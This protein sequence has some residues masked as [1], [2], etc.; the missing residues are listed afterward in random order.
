MEKSRSTALDKNAEAVRRFN[1]YYTQRIGVL[2]EG[3]LQS[4]FS[5]TQ[6]RVLYELAYA[7]LPVI[8]SDLAKALG[9]DTGYLSRI[10][11]GFEKERL[12]T[13]RVARNDARQNLVEITHRG[14]REFAPLDEASHAQ[15]AGMLRQIPAEDHPRLLAAMRTIEDVLSGLEERGAFLLREATGN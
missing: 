15:I 12:I 11:S 14:R 2:D 7:S 6:V 1:R 5:L 9:L 13:R 4:R 10:L 3:H 8:A